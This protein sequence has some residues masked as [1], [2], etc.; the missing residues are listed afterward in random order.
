MNLVMISNLT[1]SAQVEL[2]RRHFG[3][4]PRGACTPHPRDFSDDRPFADHSALGHLIEI[5]T[6]SKP[7]LWMMFPM[8]PTTKDY[9]AQP[10]SMLTYA[11]GYAGPKSLKS[12]LKEKD[13]ISDLQMQIDESSAAT[14]IFV[15]F[16]LTPNGEKNVKDLTA[17]VFDYFAKVR[18]REDHDLEKVYPTMQQMS[19]VTFA[20]QE[21]PDSV[22]DTVSSLAAA[23]SLYDPE[24]ILAGATVIDKPDAALVDRLTKLF[25]PDNVNLALATH[26]FD[27]KQ[28][29]Q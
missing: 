25:S 5:H 9:R 8:P 17:T 23:V 15:I 1:L 3:G 11:V 22:M 29:N 14:N 10:T 20:Y 12:R 21:A 26:T 16:D 7:Q 18:D 24:D 27:E 4:V 19:T 2:A 6:D 28:A 13:L